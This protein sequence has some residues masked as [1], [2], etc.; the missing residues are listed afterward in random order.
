M[1]YQAQPFHLAFLIASIAQ[2]RDRRLDAWTTSADQVAKSVQKGMGSMLGD[3]VIVIITG[4]MLGKLVAESGAAQRIAGF[5]MKIFGAK[6][7][8]W[9]MAFHRIDRGNSALL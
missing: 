2:H 5:L 3:L 9:A 1:G 4:A 7:M 6:H 8:T